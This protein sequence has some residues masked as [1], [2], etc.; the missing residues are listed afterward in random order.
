ME[1]KDP[2]YIKRINLLTDWLP[3]LNRMY[4]SF[5][6]KISASNS[7]INKWNLLSLNEKKE[8]VNAVFTVKISPFYACTSR[9]KS[10]SLPCVRRKTNFINGRVDCLDGIISDIEASC[11]QSKA[12]EA[13]RGVFL[14]P[15]SNNFSCSDS[16]R[17]TL[18]SFSDWL[19]SLSS[20]TKST[21]SDY[22]Q[23]RYLSGSSA[24]NNSWK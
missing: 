12:P 9:Y 22:L 17:K 8:I 14:P 10:D 19:L 6:S 15:V 3:I 11:R 1:I 13:C 20:S 2:F 24:K 21:Y 23:R 5:V 4:F 16:K 7:D 18:D